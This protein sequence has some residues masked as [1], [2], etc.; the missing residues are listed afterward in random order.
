MHFVRAYKAPEGNVAGVV[1]FLYRLC[2]MLAAALMLGVPFA[3]NAL[4][5]SDDPATSADTPAAKPS[6][7]FDQQDGNVDLSEF[8]LEKK[9]FLPVPIII[10]EPAIGY[11]GGLS[12]LFFRQSMS[13]AL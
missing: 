9:G 10:T 3:G 6:I 7:F 11:G 8:L 1:A 13:E 12:A 5:A 4:G 2:A